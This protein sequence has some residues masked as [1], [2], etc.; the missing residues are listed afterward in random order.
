MGIVVV[1]EKSTRRPPFWEGSAKRD[2]K[3]FP[4]AVQ[5]DMGV[6]LFVANLEVRHPPPNHGRDWAQESLSWSRTIV[7]IP[8]E[9]STP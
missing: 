8:I 3:Q 1:D 4:M 2:F 6:A 5:K 7:A 9:P